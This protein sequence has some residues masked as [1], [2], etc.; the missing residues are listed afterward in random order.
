MESTGWIKLH[1]QILSSKYGSDLE[2]IGLFSA[3]LLMANHKDNYTKD[4]SLI[5]KGQLMTSQLKLSTHFGIDRVAMR[6]RLRKLE[7]SQQIEQQTS[8]KNTIITILNWD[9][10]QSSEHQTNTKRTS[11]EH[12]VNTNKNVNNVKNDNKGFFDEK[13]FA[14]IWEL[15]GKKG[16]KKTS[17]I[18]LAKVINNEE[19]LVEITQGVE[20]YLKFLDSTGT[21]KKDFTTWINQECWN[22]DN[23]SPKTLEEIESDF[24]TSIGGA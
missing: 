3:L 9:K 7:Y 15:Y 16:N 21:F 23:P 11:N 24:L 2:M 8:N 18:K 4:G 22:D 20:R 10:Y 19:K 6:R 1:R 14:G 12:Q 13:M 17:R 5:K